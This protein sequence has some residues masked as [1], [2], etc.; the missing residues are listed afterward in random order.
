L[1]QHD[2]VFLYELVKKRYP[3]FNMEN[4]YRPVHGIHVS[5]NRNPTGT[6]NWG[7]PNW[8]NQW[9]EFRNSNE[10][11]ELEPTLSKMIKEKIQIIEDFYN[12]G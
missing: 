11:K 10:F 5:P 12:N 7:M 2:E 1:L 8:K 4:T 3:N 9:F 6:M